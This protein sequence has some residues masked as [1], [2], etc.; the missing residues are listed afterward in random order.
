M[1]CECI[2]KSSVTDSDKIESMKKE[3]LS[4]LKVDAYRWK[5]LY[6][7][8]CCNAF[9]EE[10]FQQDRFIGNP[11]LIKVDNDYVTKEWGQEFI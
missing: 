10:S 3:F 2:Y 11:Q 6:R 8:K 1:S 4:E 9:W 5:S 7:C